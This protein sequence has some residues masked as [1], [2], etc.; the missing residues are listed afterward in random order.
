MDGFIDGK[1]A[2]QTLSIWRRALAGISRCAISR[3]CQHALTLSYSG[4]YSGKW[5]QVLE[6]IWK[7]EGLRGM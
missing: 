4:K 5:L 7:E 1:P 3:V 2:G 6:V